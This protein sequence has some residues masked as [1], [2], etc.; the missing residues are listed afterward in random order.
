VID[1]AEF[2]PRVPFEESRQIKRPPISKG[3]RPYVSGRPVP[4]GALQARPTSARP[5]T[6]RSTSAKSGAGQTEAKEGWKSA[7]PTLSPDL[8]LSWILARKTLI[9]FCA[10][11]G[12]LA[13]IGFAATAKPSYVAFTDVMVPP[14]NLQVL[15]N[16]IYTATQQ[17]SDAQLLDIQSKLALLTSGNVLRRVVQD[18]K[19]DTVPEFNGTDGGL[20]AVLS[21][22]FASHSEDADRALGA[23][24]VL[25]KRIKIERQPGTYLAVISVWAETAD[26][27]VS[28]AESLNQAFLRELSQT[29]I[30]LASS[31]TSTLEGR[32]TELKKAATDA[33]AA[34]AAFRKANGLQGSS[35]ELVSAQSL[36]QI[37]TKLLDAQGTYL[38]KQSRYK[39]L[40]AKST[41]GLDPSNGLQSTNLTQLRQQY[42]QLNQ[43][44]ENMA[45]TYGPRHPQLLALKQQVGAVKSAISD[46]MGRLVQAAKLDMDQAKAVVDDLNRQMATARNSVSTDT[47]ALVKLDELDRDARA[48]T[49]LYESFLKRAGETSEREQVNLT[50]VRIVSRPQLPDRRSW[51]PP[52]MLLAGGGG[53]AGLILGIGLA[54]GLGFLSAFRANR[55]TIGV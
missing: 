23:A 49:S 28:V 16:D 34:V 4:V 45:E 55:K 22:I 33:A 17:Q 2:R 15:P 12:V 40:S 42:A 29:D 47:S 48:K 14:S 51:P 52:T 38:Q 27:A 21:R 11:I 19:L 44:Y 25:G 50:N 5:P 31:A 37:N 6:G 20:I 43:T 10:I 13:G 53:A 41:D 7:L 18:Q 35:G 46:E 32:L 54:A 1:K 9:V 30:D 39:Q 24:R 8:V 36:A 26:R 3:Y